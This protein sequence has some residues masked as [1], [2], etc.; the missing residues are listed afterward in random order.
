MRF[1]RLHIITA[2]LVLVAVLMVPGYAGEE[3]T[4]VLMSVAYAYLTVQCVA[5][6][7]VLYVDSSARRRARSTSFPS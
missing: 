2:G 1:A 7:A 3:P 5:A 4:G 6:L